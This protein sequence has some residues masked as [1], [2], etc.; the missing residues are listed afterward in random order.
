MT[1]RFALRL[2][3][4][5]LIVLYALRRMGDATYWDLMD[6]LNLAIHEA[7]HLVFQPFGEPGMTL[8]GSLFQVI[9]P[10]TFVFYFFRRRQRFAASIVTAWVA[11]SLLNVALY[12]SDA[13]AQALPLLG[14]DDTVHDWWFL[15]TEWDL[16]PHDTTI[17]RVVW[18]CGA[19]AWILSAGGALAFAREGTGSPVVG[20]ASRPGDGPLDAAQRQIHRG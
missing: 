3:S 17:G 1:P 14:G 10:V 2:V 11:T 5:P 4:L 6:D 18:L 7:G 9:I 8:G 12:I 13:R 15:L 16:L 20:V 19:V